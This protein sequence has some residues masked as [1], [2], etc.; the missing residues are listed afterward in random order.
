MLGFHEDLVFRM[1]VKGH[2]RN[3]KQR[4]DIVHN[5]RANEGVS[6]GEG[7]GLGVAFLV[8]HL[9]KPYQNPI[10]PPSFSHQVA[11]RSS[12]ANIGFCPRLDRHGAI[13]ARRRLHSGC[14]SR[15]QR[16]CEEL[17]PL[18]LALALCRLRGP[19]GCNSVADRWHVQVPL[20]IVAGR[21]WLLQLTGF[22]S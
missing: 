12:I 4:R 21:Y 18:L 19:R 11:A 22:R 1:F 14:L 10:V 2:H 8:S 20:R 15:H 7:D 17:R 3:V 5:L 9:R 6:V 13:V 16:C